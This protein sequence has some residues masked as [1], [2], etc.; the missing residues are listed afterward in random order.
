MLAKGDPVLLCRKLPPMGLATARF[1]IFRK[2]PEALR[3]IEGMRWWRDPC[4]P[5]ALRP[6]DGKTPNSSSSSC[7]CCPWRGLGVKLI[8][9]CPAPSWSPRAS[10]PSSIPKHTWPGSCVS[11]ASTCCIAGLR[12]NHLSN[13]LSWNLVMI[14]DR[15]TSILP[16]SLARDEIS[17]ASPRA[18]PPASTEPN[19]RGPRACCGGSAADHVVARERLFPRPAELAL[20][21]RLDGAAAFVA[22]L[23]LC[24]S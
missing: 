18:P 8:R 7:K 16:M 1:T 13:W 9:E 6:G 12:E 24:I 21:A 17:G 20:P 19:L 4:E 5:R 22:A 14:A 11:C 2:E 15:V 23:G 10:T 3:T